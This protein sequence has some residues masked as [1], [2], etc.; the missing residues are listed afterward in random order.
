M[1][2]K[3][4]GSREP[5]DVN[6]WLNLDDLDYE[7]DDK[8]VIVES[9]QEPDQSNRE[10]EVAF[11]GS[12]K[13]SIASQHDTALT[14]FRDQLSFLRLQSKDSFRSRYSNFGGSINNGSTLLLDSDSENEPDCEDYDHCNNDLSDEEPDKSFSSSYGS[15]I[16]EDTLLSSPKSYIQ[17]PICDSNETV[18]VKPKR[19]AF[20]ITIQVS[21]N[22]RFC[23][24][25]CPPPVGVK[26]KQQKPWLTTRGL[27]LRKVIV[28]KCPDQLKYVPPEDN[29]SGSEGTKSV[30]T[31]ASTSSSIFKTPLTRP[32][33]RTRSKNLSVCLDTNLGTKMVQD[34]ASSTEP[35]DDIISLIASTNIEEEEENG[36]LAELKSEPASL[37]ED[38]KLDRVAQWVETEVQNQRPQVPNVLKGLC[39]KFFFHNKCRNGLCTRGHTLPQPKINRFFTLSQAELNEAFEFSINY[40]ILF[41]RVCPIF[42]EVFARKGS[43]EDLLKMIQLIFEASSNLVTN[44]VQSLKKILNNLKKIDDI[45]FEEAVNFVLLEHDLGHNRLLGETL[46]ELIIEMNTTIP[47]NWPILR[48]L[49]ESGTKIP[50][51][52]ADRFLVNLMR[53]P[54]DYKVCREVYQH[55]LKFM[56]LDLPA[57]SGA[58]RAQFLTVSRQQADVQDRHDVPEE[59]EANIEQNLTKERFNF[60]NNRLRVQTFLTAKKQQAHFRGPVVLENPIG[61]R[62]VEPANVNHIE[63]QFVIDTVNRPDFASLSRLSAQSSNYSHLDACMANNTALFRQPRKVTPQNN[64]NN[65][66]SHSSSSEDEH[67]SNEGS[68]EY[69]PNQP[70]GLTTLTYNSRGLRYDPLED[71]WPLQKRRKSKERERHEQEIDSE[72]DRLRWGETRREETV[73][74]KEPVLSFRSALPI[75]NRSRHGNGADLVSSSS[76]FV[77]PVPQVV[78]DQ[79]TFGRFQFSPNYKLNVSLHNFYTER[80]DNVNIDEEDV[81]VLNDCVKYGQGKVFLDLVTKYSGP[82]TVQNFISMVLANLKGLN[83]LVGRT[84]MKLLDSIG[85]HQ[86]FYGNL[87]L[88]VILEVITMNVLFEFEKHNIFEYARDLLTRFLDWDSLVT[89]RLFIT[90][91]RIG[92]SL[93]GRYLFIAKLLVYTKPELTFEILVSPA[94]HLLEDYSKWPYY[95]SSPNPN[96]FKADLESRNGVLNKFFQIGFL[97]NVVIV[98]E[99]YKKALKTNEGIWC[100]DVRKYVDP[101]VAKL[102]NVKKIVFLKQILPELA[103]FLDYLE[104]DTLRAC[105]CLMGRHLSKKDIFRLY[106]Q[107]TYK[108]VYQQIHQGQYLVNTILIRTDMLPV[109]IELIILYYFDKLWEEGL[110]PFGSDSLYIEIKLPGNSPPKSKFPLLDSNCSVFEM[111]QKVEYVLKTKCGVDCKTISPDVLMVERDALVNYFGAHPSSTDVTAL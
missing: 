74:C 3:S 8:E 68:T 61:S 21:G 79:P 15:E 96:V 37:S 62:L 23:I 91:T 41:N 9:D 19:S 17:E 34:R 27:N 31:S 29:L 67:Q 13:Q 97:H 72:F 40:P 2:F 73:S 14:S 52:L 20:N 69:S 22:D 89:S 98:I 81:F 45:S 70:P 102:I 75:N 110:L 24:G 101:M 94:L 46:L 6:G 99:L 87:N 28:I 82:V 90:D 76:D 35:K 59:L 4:Y 55:I 38:S 57:V 106:D 105:V 7:P 39:F 26:K 42:A 12:P 30:R 66:R 111:K 11:P 71:Y 88:R 51:R 63:P 100:F 5:L 80:I 10:F 36:K 65:K 60:E 93:V 50:K 92:V 44:K 49:I 18:L 108:Q 33:T 77:A 54:I 1:S 78:P 104:K 56:C 48:R 86:N 43:K 32:P 85:E 83:Q 53:D 84:Y 16:P 107:C 109:E 95:P 103:L 25:V 58:V 47:K 64:S